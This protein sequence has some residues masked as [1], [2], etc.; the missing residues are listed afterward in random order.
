MDGHAVQVGGAIVDS[1]NF[2]WDAC[3]HKY[4]GLT[5]PDESYHGVIYTK[6]FGK[7]A[8][9]TKA[10]SQLMR[11][12]GSIPSP[13]NCFLLNL[14]LETLPLRVERHCYNAQRI[15]EF[16]NAHEKVSHV[17]YAGLPDDNT[18]YLLRNT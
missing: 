18:M 3:G 4:H 5:E 16:L 17:N 8:Y 2:D 11:D 10:T 7:K 13:T 6:Q 15:A 14:G 1:G 9:I 12:L